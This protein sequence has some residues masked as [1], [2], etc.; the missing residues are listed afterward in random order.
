MTTLYQKIIRPVLLLWVLA[1]TLLLFLQK[2]FTDAVFMPAIEEMSMD[3]L[4]AKAESI[5]YF[6]DSQTEHL[7]QVAKMLSQEESLSENL[8]QLKFLSETDETFESLGIVDKNGVVHV[9]SGIDFSITKREYYQIIQASGQDTVLSVPVSS[10]ENGKMIVL[11]LSRLGW[12]NQDNVY[13]SGAIRTDHIRQ[14]LEESN[15]FDFHIEVISDRDRQILM[16]VGREKVPKARSYLCDVTAWPG[17][18]LRL[19]IPPGFLYHRL[20][21]MN[22][23]FAVVALF[24]LLVISVLL[25]QT[26]ARAVR[27]IEHLARVM[28]GS[29]LRQLSPEKT[30]SGI[31]EADRLMSSYNRMVENTE[32][33]MSELEKEES[34]KRDA[35]YQALIQQIKPHFLYNT[36][37]MIQ[38]MCLDYEDDRVENAIGLLADFFRSS[39]GRDRFLIPLKEELHQVEDYLRLQLLRYEG[40]F[41]YEILDE[42]DGKDWFMR[43]TLQPVVENAIYHGVK[44]SRRRETITIRCCHKGG[45]VTVFVE[46]TCESCDREKI[47]Q[48]E[49]LFG[50]RDNREEYPGYGLYNVNSRL[51]LHFGPDCRLHI[52]EICSGVRVTITHPAIGEKEANEYFNCR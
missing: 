48:L 23:L 7:K 30:G 13:I 41:G 11:I 21:I 14:I 16:S 10:I 31:L 18:S 42:T 49:E 51:K 25:K 8:G 15:T 26:T 45:W 12:E 34:E 5:S 19:E 39:L 20:T 40:Q 24:I 6:L 35:Q 2:F 46:N 32:K 47:W 52:Q 44:R 3:I 36:L 50:L 33:L 17:W 28:D 29:H 27:P 38:S 1:I 4:E 22:G 43:F 9:T 37:E